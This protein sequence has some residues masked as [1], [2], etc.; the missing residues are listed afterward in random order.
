MMTVVASIGVGVAALLVVVLAFSS[1]TRGHA[2]DDV[3]DDEQVG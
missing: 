1:S 2:F 3:G